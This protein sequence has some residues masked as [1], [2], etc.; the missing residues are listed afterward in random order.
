MA[1]VILGGNNQY[2]IME[3]RDRLVD[4]LNAVKISFKKGFLP[5]GGTALLRAS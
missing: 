4:G 5:G 1:V 3:K 2:E